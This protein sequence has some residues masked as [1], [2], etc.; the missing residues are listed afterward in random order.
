M[1]SRARVLITFVVVLAAGA[2]L[3]SAIAQW[4]PSVPETVEEEVPPE[5]GSR[6]RVEVLNAGGQ[7]GMA[8]RATDELRDRGFDVVYFGNADRFDEVSSVVLDRVGRLDAARAVADALFI[9]EIR[10]EPDTGL[11]LDV[12]VRLGSGWTLPPDTV[13]VEEGEREDRWWDPTRFFR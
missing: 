13:A 5:L 11:Y 6:V 7:A 8:Q 3:G 12:T 4:S 10:S 9:E 1:I 2:L